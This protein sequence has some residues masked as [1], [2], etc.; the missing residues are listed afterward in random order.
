M[1]PSPNLKADYLA[2]NF[3]NLKVV[4]GWR[5]PQPGMDERG[6]ASEEGQVAPLLRGQVAP[7]LQGR[8]RGQAPRCLTPCRRRAKGPLASHLAAPP[9]ALLKA[10][11]INGLLMTPSSTDAAGQGG[12]AGWLAGWVGGVGWW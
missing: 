7:L 2:L 12:V 8:W 3:S 10:V 4:Q 11:A 5:G 1:L 6:G 9:Q